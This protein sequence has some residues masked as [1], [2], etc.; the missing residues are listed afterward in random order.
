MR[1][2][3][4][5]YQKRN[6]D[7]RKEEMMRTREE[8]NEARKIECEKFIMNNVLSSVNLNKKSH[9]LSGTDRL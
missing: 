2:A 7:E 9:T 3:R 1:A 8:F 6:T 5:S 4:K